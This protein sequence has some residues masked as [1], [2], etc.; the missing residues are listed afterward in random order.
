VR[1]IGGGERFGDIVEAGERD[2]LSAGAQS[3]E[4]ALH[5]RMANHS[6][7]S[8]T[9]SRKDH[10]RFSSGFRAGS[11]GFT[12]NCSQNFGSR[13]ARDDRDGYNAAASGFDFLPADDLVIGPVPTFDQNVGKEPGNHITRG[14]SVENDDSVNAF[15]RGED[16]CTFPFVDNGTPFALQ[17]PNACIAVHSDDQNVTQFPGLLED[18]DVSRVEEI[19]A[20]IGK[21]Y[22][23]AVAFLAAKPQNRFLESEHCGVQ[24]ISMPARTRAKMSLLESLVYH[25]RWGC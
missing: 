12:A 10:S 4:G 18:A 16:F 2:V 21:N 7:Q 3:G 24:G 9:D 25:A 20:A 8:F 11:V 1:Q 14:Q 17:L 22:A 19:K 6:L 5:S 15:E 13:I 23:A